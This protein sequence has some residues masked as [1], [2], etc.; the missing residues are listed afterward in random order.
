M[1]EF[2]VKCN[3]NH[4]KDGNEVL[5]FVI[6]I[7]LL[8]L[9]AALHKLRADNLHIKTIMIL[10]FPLSKHNFFHSSFF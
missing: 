3:L 5:F 9:N 6:H 2:H 7:E 10:T 8:E 1:C 4:N